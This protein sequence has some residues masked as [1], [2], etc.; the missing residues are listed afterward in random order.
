MSFELIML[1]EIR[2]SPRCKYCLLHL[3]EVPGVVKVLGTESKM[4]AARDWGRGEGE[5]NV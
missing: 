2:Q 5:V 4:V 3:Y 1:T